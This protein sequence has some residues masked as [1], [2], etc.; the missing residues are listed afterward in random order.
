MA[1][2]LWDNFF[3]SE[4]KEKNVLNLLSENFLFR[5]L[6]R[7]ETKFIADIVHL[8]NY[9]ATEI[10]FRQGEIGVGM[11]IVMKGEVEIL[12][13]EPVSENG[14]LTETLV[15]RLKAGDFFGELALLEESGPRP[16]TAR[17]R[18]ETVL[19]GFFKPDLMDVVS[20]NP[21]LGVKIALRLSEILG[22]RLRETNAQLSELKRELRRYVPDETVE[23]GADFNKYSH[24]S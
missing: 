20:R 4:E 6:T 7:N 15:T 13:D 21:G 22:R 17:A 14:G 23:I 2:Y 3:R 11:Y 9:H 1:K 16:A 8:R 18:E 19:V 12:V 5:T 10:I 24:T